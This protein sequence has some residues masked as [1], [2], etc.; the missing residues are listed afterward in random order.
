MEVHGP[1]L[2]EGDVDETFAKDVNVVG[3]AQRVVDM[4]SI[5]GKKRE[6]SNH[7]RATKTN[8]ADARDLYDSQGW[9][10]LWWKDSALRLR[11]L[12]PSRPENEDCM[13]V[14]CD[15]AILP[16]PVTAEAQLES[17]SRPWVYWRAAECSKSGPACITAIKS[18]KASLLQVTHTAVSSGVSRLE[19]RSSKD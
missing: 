7:A 6:R 8:C 5:T 19:V 16:S 2:P 1:Q 4:V 11:N 12:G 10:C 18:V 13:C 9:D 3:G 14:L 15:R 17:D